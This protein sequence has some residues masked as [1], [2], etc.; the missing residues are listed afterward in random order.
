MSVETTMDFLSH[1]AGFL[2]YASKATPVVVAAAA[3]LGFYYREKLKAILAKSLSVDIESLRH[4]FAKDLAEHTSKLQRDIESYKVSL[5]A[6]SERVKAL[7]DVKKAVALKAAERRFNAI[8]K[9]LDAHLGIDTEI[10]VFSK[11]NRSNDPENMLEFLKAREVLFDRLSEY[12]TSFRQA[13]LFLTH[14]LRG[15]VLA[16]RGAALEVVNLRETADS[17]PTPQNH[18]AIESLLRE[19]I[20]LEDDLRQLL[21]DFENA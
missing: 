14:D 18:P 10:G 5:I 1:I 8:S 9:L 3:L 16:V 19:T 20:D 21:I 4:Q 11:W 13:Q 6:E 2:D 7:Q 12:G 17:P 15:K